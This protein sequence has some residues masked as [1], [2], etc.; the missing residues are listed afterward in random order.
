MSDNI[1]IDHGWQTHNTWLI[2]A[3]CL[4]V[5]EQPQLIVTQ[6]NFDHK[7]RVQARW[8]DKRK[9]PLDLIGSGIF[10]L[11]IYDIQRKH[12]ELIKKIKELQVRAK[13]E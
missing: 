2:A 8:N 6:N 3:L 13:N 12:Q 5:E 7:I 9:L 10:P 4:M 1:K 11:S